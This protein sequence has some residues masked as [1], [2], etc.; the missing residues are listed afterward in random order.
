MTTAQLPDRAERED[1]D[2][3]DKDHCPGRCNARYRKAWRDHRAAAAEH[4]NALGRW[5]DARLQAAGDPELL[6]ALDRVRP[7]APVEPDLAAT[8]GEPVWCAKDVAGIRRAL[9]EL[10]DLAALLESWSDGHRGAS[11]RDRTGGSRAGSASPSPSPIADTLDE[12]YRALAKVEDDWREHR[13]APPRPHRGAA[14][15]RMRCIGWLMGQ[16]DQILAHPAS[17]QFGKATMAWQRRLQELTRSDPV[18]RRRPAVPCPRCD[19]RA[20]RTRDDGYT[21][22]GKCGR[23]LSE[24]EYNELADM[25]EVRLAIEEAEAS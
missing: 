7:A 4:Q 25:A 10:D 6:A 23:L 20:L 19:R 22:C 17:V 11:S 9:A 12:L 24:E 3:R 21:Q 8:P 14:E 18:V 16:L 1:R 15:A 5:E 2:R 13:G